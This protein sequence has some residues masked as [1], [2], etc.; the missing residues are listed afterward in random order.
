[1]P[2]HHALI[3][4][5]SEYDDTEFEHLKYARKDA[6]DVHA[7]LTDSPSAIFFPGTSRCLPNLNHDT[8]RQQLRIFFKNV[9][10]DDLVLVYFA[11]HAEKLG[12]KLFLI[13]KD[14]E[15][16][17]LAGSAFNVE[18]L[19][20]YFEEKKLK[21]Y[22]VV[23]DCCQ[24]G[25][26]VH[27]PGVRA[28]GE[29]EKMDE[30][31]PQHFA[32]IGKLF[33]T[34]AEPYQQSRESDVLRHGFFSYYFIEGIENGTAA[35]PS[36][37]FIEADK[38]CAYI[39]Q[40]VDD[41]HPD[42]SQNIRISGQDALG[43][44]YIARN[45]KY[46]H[47]QELKIDIISLPDTSPELFGREQEL[48]MLDAAW[49]DAQLRIVTLI[50]W[51][52]VG[53]SSL[54]NTWRR[55]LEQQEYRGA[56]RVFGWSFYSQ[57]T[58]EGKQA[59]ADRFFDEA[60]TFFGDP[61]PEAGDPSAKARRLA[62]LI[63]AQK[64]LLLLD[65]LEPLQYPPGS[66]EGRLKDRAL[67]ALLRDLA[68]QNPGLCLISSRLQVN[69]LQS[70]F[71]SSVQNVHLKTLS[72]EAGAQVLRNFGVDGSDKEMHKA[73]KEFD[74]HA[75]A[76]NLL[77]TYLVNVYE[78]DI[79]KRDKI[80]RLVYE[81]ERHG[82]HARWVMESYEQWFRQ[83]EKG[84]RELQI[85][86]LMGLFDRPARL[87]AI[88][89]LLQEPVIPG[90]T[91]TIRDGLHLE[92]GA[93]LDSSPQWKFAIKDLQ[94]LRLLARPDHHAVND[95]AKRTK[96]DESGSDDSGTSPFKGFS[97]TSHVIHGV[98]ESGAEALDCH[99]LIR[100]HFGAKL[101]QEQPQS[102]KAAHSRLYEY[103]KALPEKELPDTLEEMEP[104]F[105]AVAHGCL[106]GRHQEAVTEVYYS[107]IQRDGT[108]NYCCNKLGAFGA[109]LAALANFFEEVWSRPA[110]DLT[111]AAKAVIL[112]WAGFRLRALGRLRE[113][114][115]PMQAGIDATVEQENWKHA[116]MNA[117]N[118]S[119][120]WLS[121]GEVGRAVEAARQSVDFADR[122]GDR[123][124]QYATRTTL[125]DALHQAA[126]HPPVPSLGKRGGEKP[127][128][129]PLE[130]GGEIP[131]GPPLEKGGN[132]LPLSWEE[133]GTG[134]EFAEAERLFREAEEM[135]HE[136]QPDYPY[137]Y[138]L[139][140]FRYC[141]LLLSLGRVQEVRQRAAQ[142]LKWVI[143][144]NADILS[145][146]LDRLSLGRA[147]LLHA[148][149]ELAGLEHPAEVPEIREAEAWLEQ[150]VAGLRESGRS[151][152][153]PLG[154]LVRATLWRVL[155]D[156]EKARIDLNEVCEIATRSE[157][158]LF[159]T[160]YHL[161]A[162]RLR[163]AESNMPHAELRLAEL[164]EHLEAAA[165]LIEAT[166]YHRRDAELAE[167]REND[168]G[169]KK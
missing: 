59:S 71:K 142:T 55:N 57:G 13:M 113:A 156:F 99:P 47:K 39:Q 102:W 86:R 10:S 108:T 60:L 15:K 91:D 69:D 1:M 75:L 76:L 12:S 131:P 31:D 34:A 124:W 62:G 43:E 164:R 145:A 78:G 127:S 23:L 147:C 111:E 85:L 18:D 52:G 101:K 96:P 152:I 17:N 63:R 137:L 163:V 144:Y 9:E 129:P 103:Y 24:A 5:N 2:Q 95:V 89:A 93:H 120:L 149:Q 8:L 146:A 136:R 33:I 79:R 130:K 121:V 46:R 92:A 123:F 19:I 48:A 45:P 141:D 36:A 81:E 53:K 26:A 27:S 154:L 6:E 7:L 97:H 14:S 32:G 112:S 107:R 11:G 143:Q 38:L 139:Q 117:G 135:L 100:E 73:V 104:L 105:A 25:Q 109:D 29:R 158:R 168:S 122:S 88:E 157:M 66:E 160:D 155:G 162:A 49:E 132:T 20:P 40:Q 134:G 22:I 16:G 94:E 82:K 115:Q 28:R 42:I 83:S 74:G 51:G 126:T 37:K 159:L 77:G 80:P 161:E 148:Q 72:P 106:A 119:E 128:G 61:E 64:S 151:D 44:L 169:L 67:C 116:A 56:R 167:L 21:R 110:A 125:A 138:S 68:A 114:A 87:D 58:D 84:R 41:K 140:G 70:Y 166:G 54:M 4:G 65:G 165:R 30:Y 118:L 133:R 150:A 3:I 50:A 153:L 90:L 98:A 35:K